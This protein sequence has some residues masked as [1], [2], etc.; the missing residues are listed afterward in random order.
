MPSMQ[1]TTLGRKWLVKMLIFT[2]VGVG[3]AVWGLIDASVVYPARGAR[4]AEHFRFL[5]VDARTQGGTVPASIEFDP[6]DEFSRLDT[7]R[8]LGPLTPADQHKFGWLEQL[9]IIGRLGPQRVSIPDAVNE[10]HALAAKWRQANGS[11]RA[12]VPLSAYD[13]AIQWGMC[14]L[15]VVISGL[16]GMHVLRVSRRR[17]SWDPEA[18]RLTLP[19]GSSLTPSDVTEFDKRKWDK[20]LIFLRVREGHDRHGGRELKLDLYHH[21]PLEEWVLEM[22]R[23][24]FPENL[25]PE[26]PTGAPATEPP[27]QPASGAG[28]AA[29]SPES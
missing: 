23:T 7:A 24:A 13:L 4:A 11:T 2:A 19:D 3:L 12:A 10:F 1:T 6:V 29:V 14:G 25:P 20:F 17:Y 9:R 8:K 22:E 15:G 21:A 26:E 5:Y 28:S 18:K 16:L 27:P